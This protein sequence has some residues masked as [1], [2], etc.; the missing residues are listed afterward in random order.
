MLPASPPPTSN[1][2]MSTSA[3]PGRRG[4]WQQPNLPAAIG[5]VSQFQGLAEREGHLAV[6]T[7]QRDRHVPE[8]SDASRPRLHSEGPVNTTAQRPLKATVSPY[9]G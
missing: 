8:E 9:T 1:S 5:L 4:P 6:L 7:G 3:W 2:N